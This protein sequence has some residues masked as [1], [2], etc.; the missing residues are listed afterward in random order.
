MVEENDKGLYTTCCTKFFKLGFC[1]DEPQPP[2]KDLCPEILKTG[3]KEDKKYK[4]C[5]AEHL[6]LEEA[7]EVS[8]KK[9][10]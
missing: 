8:D 7:K 10:P 4:A 1:Y 5:C 9:E 2:A 3:S 6:E